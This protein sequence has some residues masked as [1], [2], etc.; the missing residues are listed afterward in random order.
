[1]C[2][3]EFAPMPRPLGLQWANLLLDVTESETASP[4]PLP[5]SSHQWN[6]ATY[7]PPNF[8]PASLP[9]PSLER[10]SFIRH[11]AKPSLEPLPKA[12][13]L[14]HSQRGTLFW[15]SDT[16]VPEA[17]SHL[18]RHP[19]MRFWTCHLQARTLYQSVFYQRNR[20]CR[21]WAHCL[22]T[23]WGGL[24]VIEEASQA[25]V[26]L[27]GRQVGWR[28]QKHLCRLWTGLLLPQENLV[29]IFRTFWELEEVHSD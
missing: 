16:A 18:T 25:S 9:G 6:P 14:K 15:V 7:R 29:L 24:N 28:L 11:R 3:R 2:I 1:M 12:F 20:T 19:R 10:E 5:R 17:G 22:F 26:K 13:G 23:P 4:D 27:W 21:R 8:L